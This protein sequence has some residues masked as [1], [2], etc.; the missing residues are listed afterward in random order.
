MG[1]GET[2]G[3]GK[4]GEESEAGWCCEVVRVDRVDLGGALG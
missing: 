4:A 2:G 3:T 1:M